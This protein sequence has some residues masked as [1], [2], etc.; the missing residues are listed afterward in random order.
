V[1]QVLTT[2]RGRRRW[3][4]PR[5]CRRQI[6]PKQ[7]EK[8]GFAVRVRVDPRRDLNNSS[9]HLEGEGV[10]KGLVRV[11]RRLEQVV[12]AHARR[13][14]RLVGVAPGRVHDKETLVLTHSLGI[15]LGTL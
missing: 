11:W 2:S 9:P 6:R 1:K 10:G 15:A 3:K 12:G 8:I 7:S 4:G 13:E 14:E 5:S